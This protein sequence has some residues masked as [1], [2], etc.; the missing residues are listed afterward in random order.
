[1]KEE[2]KKSILDMLTGIKNERFLRQICIIL[3]LHI[4]KRGE[5]A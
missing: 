1:M 3:R 4:E 2:Y 5:E